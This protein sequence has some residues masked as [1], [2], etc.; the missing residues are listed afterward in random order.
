MPIG[1]TLL[2]LAALATH[3]C[4]SGAQ[5][6][7]WIWADTLDLQAGAAGVAPLFATALPAGE[8]YSF[9]LDVIFD[10]SVLA[11][12]DISTRGTLSEGGLL[13]SA[14]PAPGRVRIAFAT[15]SPL[16]SEGALCHLLIRAGDQAGA[17]ALTLEAVLL[18]ETPPGRPAGPGRV[19]L[20]EAPPLP[21]R[22]AVPDTLAEAG[23]PIRLPLR[24]F[25]SAVPVYSLELDLRYDAGALALVAVDPALTS[26]LYRVDPREPGRLSVYIASATPWPPEAD[27]FAMTFDPVAEAK[28]TR[29]T[30][31]SARLNE[32]PA[33]TAL[34]GGH[35]RLR[36]PV[37]PGDVDG[38]RTISPDD[39]W[40]VLDFLASLTA[41]DDRQTRAAEVSGNGSITSYDAALILQRAAGTLPCFP[42]EAACAAGKRRPDDAGFVYW[43]A[44]PGGALAVGFTAGDNATHGLTV[45][46]PIDAGLESTRLPDD[47]QMRTF[48]EGAYRT[49]VMAGPTALPTGHIALLRPPA[50]PTAPATLVVDDR[51]F[52]LDWPARGVPGAPDLIAYPN[53]AAGPTTVRFST[54]QEG[55]AVLVLYDAIGRER[56][57][58]V[59]N[60]LP[61]GE[62]A[63]TVGRRGLP[64]GVYFLVLKTPRGRSSRKLAFL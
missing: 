63:V 31:A 34:S 36:P 25:G 29:L 21:A 39:A 60:P 20:S 32:T 26:A 54:E 53:P 56:V 8:V 23:R 40:R 15:D 24:L 62:H 2:F 64:A 10:P 7:A 46:L 50:T 44:P 41:F 5:D 6:N 52:T 58:L 12:E 22:F 57:R 59:D 51:V 55:P 17:S 47:W 1:R 3:T 28:D 48:S 35:I 30:L 37:I 13:Y 33:S 42:V 43:D 61:A 38:D 49:T 9:Q 19:T 16:A 11:I 45:R 4:P 14:S 27:L 18:N